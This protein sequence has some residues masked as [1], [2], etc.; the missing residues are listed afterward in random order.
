MMVSKRNFLF[1]GAIFQVNHCKGSNFFP[2]IQDSTFI[3]ANDP[4]AFIQPDLSAFRGVE[5]HGS[6][7][8]PALLVDYLSRCDERLGFLSQ[9]NSPAEWLIHL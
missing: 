6:L 2:G 3:F 9:I 5:V 7:T 1:R 8:R 4:W